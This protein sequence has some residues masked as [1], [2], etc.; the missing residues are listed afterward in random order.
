MDLIFFWDNIHFF[1]NSEK[2]SYISSK[3][4]FLN[5]FNVQWKSLFKN[6]N[7]LKEEEIKKMVDAITKIKL[8]QDAKQ[9]NNEKGPTILLKPGDYQEFNE[10]AEHIKANNDYI[11]YLLNMFYSNYKVPH[12]KYLLMMEKIAIEGK[13][14]NIKIVFYKT[15]VHQSLTDSTKEFRKMELLWEKE[16]QEIANRHDAKFVNFENDIKISCRYFRDVSHL[17]QICFPE[18]I[19]KIIEINN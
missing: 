10:P 19:E 14:R 12:N 5:Y 6:K 7:T 4:F 16:L 11:Q 15:P 1:T 9:K 3:I 18:V 17:S 8:M 2:I 13:A